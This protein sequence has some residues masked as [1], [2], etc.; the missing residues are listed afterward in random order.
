[1][2]LLVIDYRKYLHLTQLKQLKKPNKSLD[3]RVEMAEII[4][5]LQVEL[6][7]NATFL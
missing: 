2:N 4:P 5:P 6:L 1:M 7:R 3:R